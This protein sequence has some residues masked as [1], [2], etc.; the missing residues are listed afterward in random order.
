MLELN[1]SLASH[2]KTRF[3]G[4]F[5]VISKE[6]AVKILTIQDN[7][8]DMPEDVAANKVLGPHVF[9]RTEST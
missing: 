3:S 6:S 9:M 8:R 7:I 4:L 2:S 5:P 1:M